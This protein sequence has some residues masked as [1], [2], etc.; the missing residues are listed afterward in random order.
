ME[1]I[2]AV[3]VEAYPKGGWILDMGKD[4]TGWAEIRLPSIA[5]GATVKLE[6]S[7]SWSGTSRSSMSAAWGS[8]AP[9]L[10]ALP[11]PAGAAGQAAKPPASVPPAFRGGNP[12]DFPN[13]ANQ[14]DEMVGNGEPVTFRS[15][16]NYHGFRYV[17]IIG[18]E[19]AP[20]VSDASGYLIRTSY[21]RAGEF[22]SSNEL[23]NQ[24]YQ[25]VTRT[26]E[27]LT[28]GG[29]VVDCPT[30]ERLGYGGDAGTS[31]E[32]GM[33]NFASG[34]LY[35][36]WLA[37]WRDSQ[38]PATGSLPIRRRTISIAAEAA[39][40]GAESW[41]PCPGRCTCNMATRACWKLTIR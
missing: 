11:P 36:R 30:R 26:Y 39:P 3:R 20:A 35:N 38:E 19:T 31:F 37:N 2:K 29:Y 25:M 4:F 27:S 15:R 23:L 32:T 14:R 1:T 41:S 16:F 8:P 21:D 6:Y 7:T 18:I 9:P 34:G 10:W 28:L 12:T 24:I 40:C 17:R 13:T 22:S 33:F 5:K